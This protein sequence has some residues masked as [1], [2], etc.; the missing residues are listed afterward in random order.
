MSARDGGTPA[1]DPGSCPGSAASRMRTPI[2]RRGRPEDSTGG[3]GR[4]A[5][6]A[7][8]VERLAAFKVPTWSP[9]VGSVP[10]QP[11]LQSGPQPTAG[12]VKSCPVPTWSPVVGLL[13]QQQEA[14][15][16]PLPFLTPVING[17]PPNPDGSA[18]LQGQR[19]LFS[20]PSERSSVSETPVAWTQVSSPLSTPLV[21]LTDASLGRRRSRSASPQG[22]EHGTPRPVVWHDNALYGAAA[23][24]PGTSCIKASQPARLSAKF[25]EVAL[26]LPCPPQCDH[27]PEPEGQMTISGA[28]DRRDGVAASR[29]ISGLQLNTAL[30]LNTGS[31]I[32]RYRAGVLEPTKSG[33]AV[34]GQGGKSL[35]AAVDMEVGDDVENEWTIGAARRAGIIGREEEEA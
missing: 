16:Q 19:L 9:V 29:V 2:G 23:A 33:E 15:A 35:A 7:S 27:H 13:P 6:A 21:C 22:R 28:E 18:S 12:E 25:A 34:G 20:T 31:G 30:H 4:T 32:G 1:D 3:A 14:A 5:A 10:I 26:D 11:P 17:S 24:V 8:S